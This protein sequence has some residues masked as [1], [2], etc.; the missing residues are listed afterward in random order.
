MGGWFG[1]AAGE[2]KNKAYHQLYLCTEFEKT[3]LISFGSQPKKV[4]VSI[5]VV[6]VEVVFVVV[7][8]VVGVV[9]FV[10]IVGHRNLTLNL[11]KIGSLISHILLLLLLL[12][13]F[14]FFVAD[15]ET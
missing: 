11:V 7:G 15:P 12:S 1:G 4:V 6:V 9:V 8:I 3:R 2:M 13:L 10:V 5:V 14:N